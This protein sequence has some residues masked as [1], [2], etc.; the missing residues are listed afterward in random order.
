MNKTAVILSGGKNSRMNY[1]TKAFLKFGEKTFIEKIL[2]ELNDFD[3]KIISCNNFEE[4]KELIS[5]AKLINDIYKNKGPIG[6]IYSALL[7]ASFDSC[8][9]VAADM[10]FID[11]ELVD[12][13]AQQE[14]FTDAL[15]PVV[16]GKIEPLCGIY[17]KSCINTIETMIKE[18]NYK[19]KN[20][21]DRINVTFLPMHNKK[22]FLNINTP[23]Q[24]EEVVEEKNQLKKSVSDS[25][26][27]KG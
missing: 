2:E 21:L 1:N 8:L 15:I 19:L 5:K 10:P 20:L 22:S 24:Y 12:M 18:E 14:F 16:D 23:E 9:I 25:E 11:K 3:E 26:F 27:I 13:L 6:G 17:K 4:Y 7:S